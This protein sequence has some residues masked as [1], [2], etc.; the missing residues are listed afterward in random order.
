[1]KPK[2]LFLTAI[3]SAFTIFGKAQESS[4]INL[5]V[6]YS[7]EVDKTEQFEEYSMFIKENKIS[8]DD[9][10]KVVPD[11][12]S[13]A[14]LDS[15]IL[16]RKQKN[17]T[18]ERE[19]QIFAGF[20]RNFYLDKGSPDYLNKVYD[21]QQKPFLFNWGFNVSMS[22][23]NYIFGI[24]YEFSWAEE[25]YKYNERLIS[26][27]DTIFIKM[28]TIA[29]QI[30][31]IYSSEGNWLYDTTLYQTDIYV[32]DSVLVDT[33]YERKSIY[34]YYSY[35]SIPLHFGYRFK[36]GNFEI[37]PR[38]GIQVNFSSIQQRGTYPDENLEEMYYD[39]RPNLF[40]FSYYLNLEIRRNIKQFHVYVSPYF[41]SMTQPAIQI[42]DS[43]KRKYA[44]WG[45]NFG[46]GYRF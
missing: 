30:F 1:M 11:D 5:P 16:A 33:T 35:H 18:W 8:K 2:F 14:V 42:E 34:N 39:Y 44:T 27:K 37:V 28:D 19:V 17:N 45:V 21:E 15:L 23:K 22:R 31:G 13:D 4:W 32:M 46:V 43:F 25:K 29:E 24:G 26:Q 40:N 9:T 7:A 38:V 3:L 20:G 41:K 36:F 6:S 12:L 10:I